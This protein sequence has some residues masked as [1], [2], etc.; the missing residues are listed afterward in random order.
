[1]DRLK[2]IHELLD[3][4]CRTSTVTVNFLERKRKY[5]GYDDLYMRE[6][7]F[8]V[9]IGS[10]DFPTMGEL[11]SRL[12]VTQGA[13]TQM[14]I[15]L[16]NKGFVIRVKDTVDRRVTRVRLTESG[17]RLRT[18]HIAYDHSEH[19]LV[20]ED[21]KEFTDEELEKLIYYEK[22]MQMIFSRVP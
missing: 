21:L 12:S 2:L 3:E 13:V 19:L 15:R 17:E 7:H 4:N 22:I 5:S 18:Q 20:S 14:T 1:M 10:M 11:A 9:E 16:E 8:I 6:V